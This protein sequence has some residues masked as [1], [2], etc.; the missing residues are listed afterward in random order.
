MCA[1]T[2]DRQLTDRLLGAARL[3]SVGGV[4]GVYDPP[5]AGGS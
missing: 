1:P 2:N 4:W 5:T 3:A